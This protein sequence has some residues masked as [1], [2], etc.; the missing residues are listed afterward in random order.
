MDD[1][2]IA[3]RGRIR[4]H[5]GE[6]IAVIEAGVVEPD[7]DVGR[8]FLGPSGWSDCRS[9]AKEGDEAEKASEPG[10]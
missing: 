1:A 10:R 4:V 9:E 8:R 5:D 3:R 6:K 7:E 2:G